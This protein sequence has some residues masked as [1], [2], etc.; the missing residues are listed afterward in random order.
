ME[1]FET[2]YEWFTNEWKK[3]T[4]EVLPYLT[5]EKK[6]KKKK[7]VC[8]TRFVRTSHSFKYVGGKLNGYS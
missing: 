8:T 3:V 5:G 6:V 4:G 7:K 1:E 2:Y